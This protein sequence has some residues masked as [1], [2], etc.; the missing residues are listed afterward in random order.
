M[1]IQM[2]VP[3]MRRMM[4]FVG[5]A[6]AAAACGADSPTVTTP[7][8]QEVLSLKS[9]YGRA[10]PAFEESWT[11]STPPSTR[12][13]VV[14]IAGGELTLDP[15]AQRYSLVMRRDLYRVDTIG[16]VATE[17]YLQTQRSTDRGYSRG[18]GAS[19]VVLESDLYSGL[20][21]SGS[22]TSGT[23]S[24]G[25]REPGTDTVVPAVFGTP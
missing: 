8:P 20:V 3:R 16:G 7:L 19:A 9:A 17:V 10:L 11:D 23:I 2:S 15:A 5:V 14:R 25:V 4:V 6:V 21:H 24:V 18:V 12:I 13:Y 22:R 1:S